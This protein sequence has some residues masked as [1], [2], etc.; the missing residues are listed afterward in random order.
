MQFDWND[1]R[2][3]VFIDRYALK[4]NGDLS[5]DRV[6]QMWNR[7][8]GSIAH[9]SNERQEFLDILKD[10]RFLPAGR[11]LSGA[12]SG[13]HSATFY[14]CFVLG[15]NPTDPSY[16]KDSRNAILSSISKMVEITCRGGGVGI[17]WSVL[18]PDKSHVR[19][20]HGVSTGS[21]GWMRGADVLADQV[22]QGGS[23][24]AAL[25]FMLDD[26]H[27]D[28]M[29]FVESDKFLRANFSVAISDG[30]MN[31][32]YDNGWWL[33]VFPNTSDPAY[34]LLW[35]GD[36]DKWRKE[37]RKVVTKE[38]R[39]S[40]IW[41]SIC[42]SAL[43]HGNPGVVF[44]NRCNQMSNTYYSERL[45]CTN[46]CGEQPLPEY[47]SCNL[48]SINLVSICNANGDINRQELSK[49]I[50]SAVKFLDNVIDKSPP[51]YSEIDGLQKLYRRIGLGTMG[52]ADVLLLNK[53]RYGSEESLDFISELYSF[54]RDE[55]YKADAD[56][57]GKR[58]A[59]PMFSHEFLHSYMAS[60]LE[61]ALANHIRLH[62]LRNMSVL[63]QAP[64]G[65]I[66]ILAGVSS[67]IEPIF[68]AEYMR[69]DA[70]GEYLVKHPLLQDPR[71][72]YE[73]TAHEVTPEEHIEVQA[74][75]QKFVDSS[76]SKTINM[77]KG[78]TAEDIDKA[79]R[80]GWERG[81]KGVTIYVD[82]SQDNILTGCSSGRCDV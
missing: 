15:I 67:G 22:R 14:N 6:S 3:A 32:L 38:I 16:G 11:I 47:G 33:L 21:V 2:E 8:A 77:P 23:R 54:I 52:L 44:I 1:Q 64:T 34:D 7:V 68:N 42:K 65:T 62:G 74:R 57:A 70:T 19:G 17:N 37:G 71:R 45:I 51:L 9:D 50:K 41:G 56:L 82:G 18:R 61:D 39:A 73:V 79:Y 75:L 46:P 81:V 76:I 63:T 43:R 24:T 35:D 25:M 80:L 13:Q 12:G 40:R 4:D 29:K 72:A 59:A 20:V 5:E 36:I 10:F 58:G 27:P 28:I 60:D 26:W 55:A 53:I 49:V 48:G 78:T 31:T 66:S 69:K 30:F